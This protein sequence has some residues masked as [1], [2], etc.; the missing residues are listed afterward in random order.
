MKLVLVAALTIIPL[1]ASA[2][3]LYLKCDG[4]N[5]CQPYAIGLRNSLTKNGC[6]AEKSQYE[7]RFASDVGPDGDK[8]LQ[9][10]HKGNYFTCE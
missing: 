4:Y 6:E 7:A 3:T 9:T 1:S 10:Y 8:F 5:T 2:E